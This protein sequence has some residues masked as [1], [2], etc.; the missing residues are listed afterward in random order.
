MNII[1][2]LGN[3]TAK[4]EGTRHNAGFAVIDAL[5]EK[6]DIPVNQRKCRACIGTGT[7]GGKRVL[8]AKPQ[9]FMNLSGESV[10][11]LADYYQIDVPSELIVIYDDIDLTTGQIR[12]RLKGSAGSHNGMKNILQNLGTD[13][14]PRVRLGTGPKPAE[15][16]LVNY[17]LGHFSEGEQDL[18]EE[19][20]A[21]AVHAVEMLA[22]GEGEAAMNEY[23]RKVKPQQEEL[24]P[25]T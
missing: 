2:G 19:A 24:P 21:R 8:L 15:M 3:P 16:D 6:Y 20:Y 7:L 9:T 17:V 25:E 11:Q 23:N 1:V 12:V 5:S 10:R 18:M 13:E 14:F 22:A 4:Y